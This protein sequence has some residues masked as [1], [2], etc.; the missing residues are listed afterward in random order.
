MMTRVRVAAIALCAVD[1][2]IAWGT[3]TSVAT[4][5]LKTGA[6]IL[7]WIGMTLQLLF[8]VKASESLLALTLVSSSD[9]LDT[10]TT[11]LTWK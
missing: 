11:I 5:V 9:L 10:C 8:A 6:A 1:S 3:G 2:F 4:A 7:T